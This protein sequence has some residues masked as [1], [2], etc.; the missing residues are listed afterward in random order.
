MSPDG[1]TDDM[2]GEKA[3][4]ERGKGRNGSAKESMVR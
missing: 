2:S 1:N 4:R 3:I